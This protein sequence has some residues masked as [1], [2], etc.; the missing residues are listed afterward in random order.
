MTKSLVDE[1]LGIAPGEHVDPLGGNPV[2]IAWNGRHLEL[3]VFDR[4]EWCVGR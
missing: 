4:G 3:E 1:F 2:R